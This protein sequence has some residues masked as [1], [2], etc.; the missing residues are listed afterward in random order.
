MMNERKTMRHQVMFLA[1]LS[2]IAIGVTPVSAQNLVVNGN[3]DSD[4]SSWN[5]TTPGTFTHSSSLDADGAAPASGSGQLANTSPVAY[6]TSFAAQCITTGIVAGNSYDW[7]ARIRF[8]SGNTQTAT[9]RATVVVSFFDG[10]SCSGSNVG[11]STTPNFL[12]S[13][14]DVWTQMEVLGFTAPTG[15][16]SAQLG[17]WTTKVESSGTM[18]VNFDNVVLGP[19]GILPVE[20]QTFVVD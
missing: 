15:A 1:V 14:T 9:G 12:S 16:V 17:L 13:T 3:F 18:T 6:G 11:S 4:T 5:F 19:A 7:G 8:D 2:A 10:G 20:L